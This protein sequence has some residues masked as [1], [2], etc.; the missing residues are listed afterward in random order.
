MVLPRKLDERSLNMNNTTG[1]P[2]AAK[3]LLSVAMGHEW[4][5]PEVETISLDVWAAGGPQLTR[6][7]FF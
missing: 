5:H 3:F 6:E 7:P 1:K 4:A 2:N